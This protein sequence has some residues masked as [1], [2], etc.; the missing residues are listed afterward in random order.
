ME[1]GFFNCLVR[2]FVCLGHVEAALYVAWIQ[3][4][5]K[6]VFKDCN[7]KY[8]IHAPLEGEPITYIEIIVFVLKLLHLKPINMKTKEGG[9]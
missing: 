1:K 8:I 2:Y 3:K 4:T 6:Q 5:S 7:M 9:H